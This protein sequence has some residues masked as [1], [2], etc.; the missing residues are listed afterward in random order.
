ML[1]DWSS[2]EIYDSNK[3]LN[4]TLTSFHSKAI[5][6]L[7]YLPIIGL[8]ASI[9]ENNTINEWN[10]ITWS[11]IQRYENHT[12]LVNDLDQIDNDTLVSGSDDGTIHIWK[13]STGETVQKI[14]VSERVN[15]VRVLLSG[16]QI[17]CGCG[18]NLCIYNYT[19]GDLVQSPN[20][21]NNRIVYPIEILNEQFMASGDS[22]SKII[23]WDLATFSIKY[24]F[25]G[26]KQSVLSIRRLS[27]NLMASVGDDFTS[28]QGAIKLW[29]WL[30]ERD[31]FCFV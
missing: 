22:D 18:I 11:S 25:S 20:G 28:G 19:T 15:S 29:D 7:K 17:A 9:S 5:I 14:I 6:F 27:S 31:C 23:I 24:N 1:G 13:I 26:Q 30:T 16:Q 21:H 2:S 10:P 4:K 8:V 12:D 3:V